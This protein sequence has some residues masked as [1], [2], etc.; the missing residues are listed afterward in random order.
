MEIIYENSS[1]GKEKSVANERWEN[2]KTFPH[3]FREKQDYNFQVL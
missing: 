1:L 3:I 2:F